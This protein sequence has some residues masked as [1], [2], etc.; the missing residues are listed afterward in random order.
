VWRVL[1]DWSRAAQ[2]LP[3][4]EAVRVDGDTLWFTARVLVRRADG[5]QL[6]AL[7]RVVESS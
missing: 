2:W 5:D 6:G 7:K 4:V 3:G 1:T